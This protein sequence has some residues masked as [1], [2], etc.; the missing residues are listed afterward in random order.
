MYVGQADGT[1]QILKFDVSGHLV[2]VFNVAVENR[3]SD[4]IWLS[5]DQCSMYYTSEGPNVKTFNVCTNTQ[6]PNYNLDPLPDA[7]AYAVVEMSESVLVANTRVITRLTA[8]HISQTYDA[9]GED[10]WSSVALDTD[11]ASFWAGDFCTGDVYKFDIASG[12]VVRQFNTGTGKFTVFGLAVNPVNSACLR[13]VISN[14]PLSTIVPINANT[15]VSITANGDSLQYQWYEAGLAIPGATGSSYTTPPITSEQTYTVRVSNACGFVD[16][17]IAA[18]EVNMLTGPPNTPLNPAGTFAEPVNT[19]TGSYLSS[20]VDFRVKG[21]GLAFEFARGYASSDPYSGPLGAGWTHSYNVLLNENTST[22]VVTI[23]QGNGGQIYFLRASDGSYKV[24]TPGLTDT[25]TKNGDGSFTL[26]RKSQ[27]QFAFSPVGQLLKITDRNGNSQVLSYSG[28]NLATITDTVSRTFTLT[29]D[30]NHRITSITDPAKRVVHYEYDGA[31]NLYRYHDALGGTITYAYDSAHRITSAA[32]GRGITYVQNTYD[33][34]GRV[35]AQKNGRGF[36][37]T[38]AYNTPEAG[39]TTITDA[40]GSV[41]KHIYDSSKRLT[42]ITNAQS[43]TTTSTYDAQNR[44]TAVKRADGSTTSFSYDANGNLTSVTDALGNTWTFVYDAQNHLL[45]IKSPSGKVNTFTYDGNGNL[46]ASK[47]ALGSTTSFSYDSAGQLTSVLNAAGNKWSYSYDDHGDVT[48]IEDPAGNAAKFVYDVLSRLTSAT[49]ANGHTSTRSYDPLGREST[50]SDPLGHATQ[51]SYDAAGNPVKVINAKGKATTFQYDEDNNLTVVVDTLGNSN[52]YTYDANDSRTSFKN[53]KGNSTTYGYD[54][55][56]RR[57][58]VTEPIGVSRNASFDPVGNIT[59]VVDANGKTHT[60]TFDPLGRVLTRTFA[61]G[62]VVSY[63]YDADGNRIKMVDPHGTTTYIFDDLNR[64]LSVTDPNGRTVKY[65]Y[66]ALGKRASLTDPDGRVVLFAYDANGRLS[67]VTDW[68]GRVTSYSYDTAGNVAQ[69]K[70]GNGT[71]TAYVRDDANRLIKLLNASP[72]GALSSFMY[73]LDELGD[74]VQM[75]DLAGGVSHYNFDDLNRL[76]S[77]QSPSGQTTIYS[78]DPDGNRISMSGAF[79]TATYTFDASDRM[80]TAGL[81]AFT[82][83]GNGNRLTKNAAGSL[84][85]YSFNSRNLLTSVS[86]GGLTESFDY[87][88]DQNRIALTAAGSTTRYVNDIA[89]RNPVVLAE[90]AP[91]GVLDYQYGLSL[92][93]ATSA[94]FERFYQTDGLGSTVTVTDGTGALKANYLYDPWGKMLNPIDPLRGSNPY[95]FAGQAQD[96]F[97]LSYNHQRTYDPQTGT[98]LSRDPFPGFA[99]LPISTNR[100]IYAADNPVNLVDPSGFAS[101][102]FSSDGGAWANSQIPSM[103]QPPPGTTE[104]DREWLAP[105][106]S[107]EAFENVV[108]M[109]DYVNNAYSFFVEGEP[110]L[111]FSDLGKLVSPESPL[112][113]IT[114]PLWGIFAYLINPDSTGCEPSRETCAGYLPPASQKYLTSYMGQ[115]MAQETA[116]IGPYSPPVSYT[117]VQDYTPPPPPTNSDFEVSVSDETASQF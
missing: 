116:E 57:T 64:L 86:A 22:K 21:R 5:S 28:G 31:G 111:P 35:T 78:Y 33:A 85:T 26:T 105:E 43:G 110:P 62:T 96:A 117:S 3:G 72:T 58:K 76:T 14:Q 79:G 90:V 101:E 98:F 55:L 37:T 81:T 42:E 109:V 66:N 75:T 68:S 38:F 11:G 67:Q 34:Q 73:T 102:P 82:Y 54:S 50:E 9:P 45:S 107:A 32:D 77:W 44:R 65:T 84:T 25:L 15:T 23:K 1:H 48:S 63:T 27:T 70:Y 112:D 113:L 97:G 56:N 7:V 46:T 99:A 2:A 49:D 24:L 4:W 87:D 18:V 10:C 89:V 51:Y 29:Y 52:V 16:S 74:R 12:H 83:D 47:D 53:A 71:T 39:T 103:N 30:T 106:S 100:Y 13:P 94:S 59:S 61:D 88:G 41:T 40:R 115:F 8:G 36:T 93:S 6:L 20:H 104:S 69:V 91:S 114:G 19:A 108:E 95:K 17:D 80:L 60:F 92:L